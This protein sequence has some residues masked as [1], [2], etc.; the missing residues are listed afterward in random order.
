MASQT[1]TFEVKTT[2]AR[3]NRAKTMSAQARSSGFLLMDSSSRPLYANAEALK[4]LSYPAR[5]EEAESI[6]KL[7]MEKVRSVLPKQPRSAQSSA[8]AEFTSGRRRYVCRFFP[9]ALP[10]AQGSQRM[11]ALLLERNP[12]SLDIFRMAREFNLTPRECEAVEYLAQGLTSKEIAERMGISPNTVR[13]F[14]RLAMVK[15]GSSTRS[16]IIGKFLRSRLQ[17]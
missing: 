3:G 15:T 17:P 8:L 5:R 12:A 2:N 4:I 16:G 14:V 7:V 1:A 6:E 13:A 11:T 9:L 10:S